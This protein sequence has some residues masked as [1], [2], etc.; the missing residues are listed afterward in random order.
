MAPKKVWAD[1]FSS[2]D[3]NRLWV[4]L[5]SLA[6][7]L[8]H[9]CGVW[10]GRGVQ[11]RSATSSDARDSSDLVRRFENVRADNLRLAE[12]RAVGFFQFRRPGSHYGTLYTSALTPTGRS[13]SLGSKPEFNSNRE[14]E[15]TVPECPCSFNGSNQLQICPE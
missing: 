12:V 1:F 15:R 8:H 10:G 13:A 7:V 11:Q 4:G 5:V 2:S 6:M 3:Q 9:L 14:S